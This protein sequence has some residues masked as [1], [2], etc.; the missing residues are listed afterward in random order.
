MGR[1][2]MKVYARVL[3]GIYTIQHTD[4]RTTGKG[5]TLTLVTPQ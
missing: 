4:G 1:E 2:K 5:V 3:Y